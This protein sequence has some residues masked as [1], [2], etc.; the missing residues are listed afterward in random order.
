MPPRQVHTLERRPSWWRTRSDTPAH[1]AS[2]TTTTTT[3]VTSMCSFEQMASQY[4]DYYSLQMLKRQPVWAPPLTSR[5]GE[6]EYCAKVKEA[7]SFRWDRYVEYIQPRTFTTS[8]LVQ[9]IVEVCRS[10]PEVMGDAVVGAITRHLHTKEREYDDRLVVGE[11]E[12]KKYILSP[13]PRIKYFPITGTQLLRVCLEVHARVS[14]DFAFEVTK[15]VL[16]HGPWR[17]FSL[18]PVVFRDRSLL[19]EGTRWISERIKIDVDD[20]IQLHFLYM[21]DGIEGRGCTR[22]ASREYDLSTPERR[23]FFHSHLYTRSIEIFSETDRRYLRETRLYLLSACAS[24]V[25]PRDL[26]SIIL[27]YHF[28][29][30][31]LFFSHALFPLVSHGYSH[32]PNREYLPPIPLLDASLIT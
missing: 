4:A 23:S 5:G 14:D 13:Y 9:A 32:N 20:Q 25:L 11:G 12:K 27:D 30:F 2:T 24:L 6:C 8:A 1:S 21:R 17:C 3:S 7:I 10:I 28:V 31:D 29:P 18:P 22:N 15:A 26:L 16:V 19:H